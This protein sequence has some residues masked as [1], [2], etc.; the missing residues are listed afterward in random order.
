MNT[1]CRVTCYEHLVILEM[2]TS[3]ERSSDGRRSRDSSC[4]K[5]VVE[6]RAKNTDGNGKLTLSQGSAE[7]E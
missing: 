5:C 1:V 3:R 7:A 6:T 4:Y 2:V